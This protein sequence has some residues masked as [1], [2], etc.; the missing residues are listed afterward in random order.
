MLHTPVRAIAQQY[1][2]HVHLLTG[3]GFFGCR[4]D[5][6]NFADVLHLHGLRMRPIASFIFGFS[7]LGPT[8]ALIAAPGGFVRAYS[9]ADHRFTA[10]IVAEILQFASVLALGEHPIGVGWSNPIKAPLAA[11]LVNLAGVK[12]GVAQNDDVAA[13]G[14]RQAAD[15]FRGDVNLCVKNRSGLVAAVPGSSSSRFLG[16]LAAIVLGVITASQGNSRSGLR[17]DQ[18]TEHKAMTMTTR[19]VFG[20][21]IAAGFG[22]GFAGILFI[23]ISIS[24]LRRQAGSRVISLVENKNPDA[25]FGK[26]SL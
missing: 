25:G 26:G 11:G 10:Q 12:R 1:L 19:S 7:G 22:F 17:R 16:L 20:W 6:L 21:A 14:Y 13:S 15:H 4:E 3:F 9:N 18:E 24:I 5:H 2:L 23:T 8:A